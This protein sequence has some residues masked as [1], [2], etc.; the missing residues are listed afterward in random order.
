M[1][2]E[3]LEWF[4]YNVV[5]MLHH[6]QIPSPVGDENEQVTPASSPCEQFSMYQGFPPQLSKKVSEPVQAK[7][8]LMVNPTPAP[9]AALWCCVPA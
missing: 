2:N 6:D 3:R 7:L 4:L 1:E 8:S 5:P 9:N